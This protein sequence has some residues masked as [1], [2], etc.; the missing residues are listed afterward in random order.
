MPLAVLDLGS[1]SFHLTLVTA[2]RLGRPEVLDRV[3]NLVRLGDGVDDGLIEP[4]A[5]A[6]ADA[7]IGELLAR[8][9]LGSHRAGGALR[10]IAVA[11]SAIREAR[12][13]R[14]LV[15]AMRRTHGLDIEILSGEDEAALVYAGARGE[16]TGRVAVIDLGGGSMEVAVG[17]R[18][19]FEPDG[20]GCLSL[21]SLPLGVLRLRRRLVPADGYVSA[22]AALRIEAHVAAVAGPAL[23]AVQALD[24]DHVVITAGTA[25][26]VRDLI[27][28]L[29]GEGA[30]ADESR[31]VSVSAVRRLSSVL[32]Q[33]RPTDLTSLGV[34]AAR[35]DTVAVGAVAMA[36]VMDLLGVAVAEVSDRGLRDGLI[37]REQQRHPGGAWAGAGEDAAAATEPAEESAHREFPWP[38]GAAAR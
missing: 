2:D 18:P 37:A 11:T 14:A 36:A 7:A 38:P 6:R 26:T 9:R 29:D 15:A 23:A 34:S 20:R 19:G 32:G 3:K 8:A 12:N 21:A 24:P 30:T 1:N 28:E 22:S 17:D 10:T 5:W 33:F 31:A 25:R 13:G 35:T 4:G 27:D 16:R